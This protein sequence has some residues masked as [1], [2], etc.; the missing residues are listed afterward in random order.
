MTR[1]MIVPLI[2]GIV[3]VAILVSLGSWQLR[4][5]AW[6]TEILAEI[7]ARLEAPPGP[8]PATTSPEADRYLHV[9]T[10]GEILPG[11]IHVYTSA[12]PRG[13]G[14]RVIV[15]LRLAD[16]RSLLL[17]RGFVPIDE[18]D[19]PR[20]LGPITVEG[21]LDWPR[22]TDS[23]FTA[24]P[25][26]AKYIWFARVVPAMAAALGTEPLLLVTSASDDPAAPQP[27]PVTVNLPN[28]HL[29]YAL[30]WF[31]LALVWAGMTLYLLW[32]IKRRTV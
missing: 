12:P 27:L 18:K 28:D 6:K 20:H 29:G 7:A 2:F 11:E 32:R 15:P 10:S 22:E 14:Y 21:N 9:R 23:L 25:D 13:V 17:D 1:R 26:L 31:G 3:G 8:V 5:L 16:G 19:V 4:R 24:A 30:T